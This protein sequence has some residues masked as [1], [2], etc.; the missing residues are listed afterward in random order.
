MLSCA[1]GHELKHPRSIVP[2]YRYIPTVDDDSCNIAVHFDE[3]VAFIESRLK[4]TNVPLRVSR[5][6]C[7]ASP[8]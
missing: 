1:Q 5:C 4:Q 3:A 7:T 2:H 6:S 8:A